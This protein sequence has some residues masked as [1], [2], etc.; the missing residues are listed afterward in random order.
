MS[1][2]PYNPDIQYGGAPIRPSAPM[3]APA[4]APPAHGMGGPYPSP[5]Q[6]P[7]PSPKKKGVMG[8]IAGL[9]VLGL[10]ATGG[11]L[12]LARGGS[13]APGDSAGSATRGPSASAV[14]GRASTAAVGDSAST[15]AVG[16]CVDSLTSFRAVIV[17]CDD[18]SAAFKVVATSTTKEACAT[19]PGGDYFNASTCYHDLRTGVPVEE[20]VNDAKAG[21]CVTADN[22]NPSNPSVRKADCSTSGALRVEGRLPGVS[23]VPTFVLPTF[24]LNNPGPAP[25]LEETRTQY[26]IDQCVAAGA[27]GTNLV[28]SWTLGGTSLTGYRTDTPS[29][30]DAVLCLSQGS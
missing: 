22:T 17:G 5:G 8:L 4:G 14:G 30:Y 26:I 29:S 13:D 24:D 9:A 20:S 3:S 19:T 11:I 16:D 28:Y 15:A 18:A 10:L 6:P 1:T 23:D 27:T 21:D 25:S 7:Q 12:F 2:G